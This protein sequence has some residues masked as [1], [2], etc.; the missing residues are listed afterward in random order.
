MTAP[1]DALLRLGR[2]FWRGAEVSPDPRR[3]RRGWERIGS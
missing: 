3:G 2:F 1:E